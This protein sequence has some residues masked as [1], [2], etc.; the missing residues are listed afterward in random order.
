[1]FYN[2]KLFIYF[3]LRIIDEIESFPDLW[4]RR[5]RK[6][7]QDKA[8]ECIAEFVNADVDDIVFV[9]NATTGNFLL[10][11]CNGIIENFITSDFFNTMIM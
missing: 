2:M 3:I 9:Q 10:Y 6:I 5:N 1:M 11:I 8:R 7:K 4:F